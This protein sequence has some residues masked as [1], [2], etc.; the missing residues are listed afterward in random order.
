SGDQAVQFVARPSL[1]EER[2]RE[3]DQAQATAADSSVDLAAEAVADA[4]LSLVEPDDKTAFLERSG[5][6]A[7][8]RFLVFRRVRDKDVELPVLNRRTD[9]CEV[10]RDLADRGPL[11]SDRRKGPKCRPGDH[12]EARS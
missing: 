11:V 9:R 7:D 6:R 2:L 4:Q 8:D 1:A 10:L 5:Q 3:D 12:F